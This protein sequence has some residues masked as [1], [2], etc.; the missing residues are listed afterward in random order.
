MTGER[1]R[2][3][4]ALKAI[5]LGAYDFSGKPVNP[6]EL[7]VILGRAFERAPARCR[8]PR[9]PGRDVGAP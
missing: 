5:E 6:A 8:K 1:E 9:S 3:P 2:A 7:I 4:R